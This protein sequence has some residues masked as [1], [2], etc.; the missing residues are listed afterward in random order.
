VNFCDA[1][2][3]RIGA[4]YVVMGLRGELREVQARY[5]GQRA[6]SGGRESGGRESGGHGYNGVTS[7]NTLEDALRKS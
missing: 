1:G 5:Q 2:G 6:A 3:N 7:S 4:L